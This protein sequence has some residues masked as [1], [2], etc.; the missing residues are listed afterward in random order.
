MDESIDL[1]K[2]GQEDISN[3]HKEAH[4]I[5]ER[6]VS[7]PPTPFPKELNYFQNIEYSAEASDDLLRETSQRV[8]SRN[9]NLFDLMPLVDSER[10]ELLVRQQQFEMD[11]PEWRQQKTLVKKAADYFRQ[12]D[13]AENVDVSIEVNSDG[14]VR[15]T[16]IGRND[17]D[18]FRTFNRDAIDT[19]YADAFA[20][21]NQLKAFDRIK[22]TLV[23][24]A[25][26]EKTPITIDEKELLADY[27][28]NKIEH[29]EWKTYL[30]DSDVEKQQLSRTAHILESLQMQV[31]NY[32]DVA[33]VRSIP[34]FIEHSRRNTT[35][36]ILHR[37]SHSTA[38]TRSQ[39]PHSKEATGSPSTKK[40]TIKRRDL[41]R[42]N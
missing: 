25:T 29:W 14:N 31:D 2:V 28:A 11:H 33:D 15:N 38:R 35:L 7:L 8:S 21:E 42:G 17:R 27:I 36:D 13:D 40:D 41:R 16:F 9:V 32:A 26:K 5:L 30:E 10:T 18:S 3:L 22:H 24:I 4:A 1:P 34:S 37:K 19:E 12:N 20:F 23:K 6:G 39:R